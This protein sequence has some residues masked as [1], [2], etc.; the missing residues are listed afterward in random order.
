MSA[1]IQKLK[2][3]LRANIKQVKNLAENLFYLRDKLEATQETVE[4]LVNRVENLERNNPNQAQEQGIVRSFAATD[5]V[6]SA[7]QTTNSQALD[8]EEH[9]LPELI[10]QHPSWLRPFSVTAEVEKHSL[11]EEV[12]RLIRSTNGYLRVVRLTNGSEWAYFEQMS[13]ERFLRIPLLREIY[14]G[15][16]LWTESSLSY[17]WSSRPAKLQTLQRGSR[18]ELVENGELISEAQS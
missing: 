6:S 13:Q 8:L 10:I 7:H 9:E 11:E 2:E 17:I 16:Q 5:G 12:Y 1:E 4:Q 14:H 15:E 18:W 3:I